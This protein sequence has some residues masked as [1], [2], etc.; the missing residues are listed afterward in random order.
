MDSI[1]SVWK[2][3]RSMRFAIILLVLLT[4]AC[5]LASFVTQGQTYAWYAQ[6]Y[7]ERRAAVIMALHLDDA[8]HSV[9]FVVLTAFLCLNLFLCNIVR[10]PG[11]LRRMKSL[12]DNR[13]KAGIWGAWICHLGVILLILGF[14]LGQALKEE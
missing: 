5:A 6:A 8:Y 12:T 3:L 14:G 7:G 11:L 2:F 13:E 9:W 10:V 1:R 4:A